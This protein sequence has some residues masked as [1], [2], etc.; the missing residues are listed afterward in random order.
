M[1]THSAFEELGS[2]CVRDE[3]YQL[4]CWFQLLLLGEM[5]SRVGEKAVYV[6][7][8]LPAVLDETKMALAVVHGSVGQ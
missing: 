1:L 8:A 2:Q 4:S 5:F 3:K 7:P 6:P